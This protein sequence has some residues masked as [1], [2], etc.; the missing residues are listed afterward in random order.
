M[1]DELVS[2]AVPTIV[3]TNAGNIVMEPGGKV[4]AETGG[5]TEVGARPLPSCVRTDVHVP[6]G[7]SSDVFGA[8]DKV[9]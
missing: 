1:C 2:V 6:I 4:H 3:G 7:T 5:E 8:L 9:V